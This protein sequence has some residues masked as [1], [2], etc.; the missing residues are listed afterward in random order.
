M[1]ALTVFVPSSGRREEEPFIEE[2]ELMWSEV[3]PEPGFYQDLTSLRN[4]TLAGDFT[5]ERR[6]K[7][8]ATYICTIIIRKALKKCVII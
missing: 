2:P 7:H 8:R 6:K 1:A 4:F 5:Y 3:W